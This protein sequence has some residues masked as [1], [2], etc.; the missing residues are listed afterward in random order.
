MLV[1]GTRRGRP[2]PRTEVGWTQRPSLAIVEYTETI[3]SGVAAMPWP[4]AIVARLVSLHWSSGSMI[5]FDSPGNPTPVA[6]PSPNRARYV[7]S[8]GAPQTVRDHDRADVARLGDDVTEGHLHR[9]V[10]CESWIT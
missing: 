2:S 6:C 9:A 4:Y 8:A 10:G 5:P 1:E 7:A 3:W